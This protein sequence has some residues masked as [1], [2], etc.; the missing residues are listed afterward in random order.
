MLDLIRNETAVAD[1]LRYD[2]SQVDEA[3]REQVMEAAVD[4]KRRE[5]R[6]AMDIVEIGRSLIDV[7]DRLP[8]GQFV[9]WLETEFGWQKSMAYNFMAVAESFPKFGKVENFG[10]SALY[11]LSGPNVPDEAVTEANEVAERGERVTHKAAKAIVD[12]H[13]PKPANASTVAVPIARVVGKCRVCHRPLTDPSSVG[14]A[15]GPT[16]AAKLAAGMSVEP[17]DDDALQGVVVVGNGPVDDDAPAIKPVLPV[18]LVALGC[19]LELDTGFYH[20]RYGSH[21]SE[22]ASFEGAVAWCRRIT[23]TDGSSQTEPQGTR[24]E[25]IAGLLGLYRQV[26]ASL[27]DYGQLTGD[28]TGALPLRRALE[29]MVTRLEANATKGAA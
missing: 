26:L 25:R 21:R 10:L 11:L 8:Y 3:H 18:D 29:P 19:R 5:H 1:P 24:Q 16:C 27:P 22:Y 13:R 7:R 15:C 14:D 9:P 20:V 12:R 2:Y 28:F 6:A 23:G 4:I 17:D